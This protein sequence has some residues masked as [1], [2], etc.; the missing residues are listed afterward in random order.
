MKILLINPLSS[1]R[2]LSAA[3]EELDIQA[4][5]IYTRGRDG[6]DEYT[7]PDQSFFD[8]QHYCDADAAAI[9]AQVSGEHFAFVLNGSESTVRLA[10][11]LAA[12]LT[13]GLGNDPATSDVRIDKAAVQRQL[14]K[15]RLPHIRQQCVAATLE[16]VEMAVRCG[17]FGYPFFL[18]PL[19]GVGSKGAQRIDSREE[20]MAYFDDRRL[21]TLREDLVV[22]CEGEPLDHL[23][24]GEFI[25]GE[26]YFVDSFSLD[27]QLHISS[28]QRYGKH[29]VNGFPIYRYY[30]IL[31][32]PEQMAS[33]SAYVAACFEALGYRNGFAHTELFMTAYGPVLIELNPRIGG[34][35]GSTNGNAH[36]G[37]LATQPE[38]LSDALRGCPAQRRPE[39]SVAPLYSRAVTLFNFRDAPLPDFREVLAG[40]STIRSIDQA[41]RVG[42]T[43]GVQPKSLSDL[44]AIVICSSED[45]REIERQSE[46][47]LARDLSG[48]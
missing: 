27:G 3:L 20:L 39:P 8:E 21:A 6:Y 46:E 2:Y 25:D 29:H 45:P 12:R 44:V 35:R 5:A 1:A 19:R 36:L 30:D 48:W 47:I 14:A 17:E 7:R 33:I 18:K 43:R 22:F 34:I 9:L 16:A 37:G 42:S 24:I 15:H 11:E 26:E 13:P 23:L 31:R 32:D 28:I 41:G 4:T 38:I 10:D 40:Y